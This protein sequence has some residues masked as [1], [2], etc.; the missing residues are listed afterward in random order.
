VVVV[1]DN[2]DGAKSLAGLLEL[3]GHRAV[4]AHTGPAGLEAVRAARPDLAILD[5]GLPGMDGY[6]LARRLRDDPL[7]RGVVLAAV[8]GY[9]RDPDRAVGFEYHY[10]KPI[11][12]EDLQMLLAAVISRTRADAS[13]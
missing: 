11:G 9:R 1:D 5:I 8:S 3:L 4:V 7:T 6:E 13:T 12:L 10:V 2:V